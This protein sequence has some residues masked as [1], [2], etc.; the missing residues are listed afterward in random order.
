[1][2]EANGKKTGQTNTGFIRA[3]RAKN[4]E[5]YTR[6]E[7]IEAELH[8]YR[9]HFVGKTVYCNCD[10]PKV[11]QFWKYFYA[12]FSEWGLKRLIATGYKSKNSE[13]FSDHKYDTSWCKEY[14]GV[15]ETTRVLKS[16]GDFRK[17]ECVEILRRADI[18]VTNPPFSLFRDYIAQLVAEKKKFLVIGNYGSVTYKDI[19]QL[20]MAGKLWI[21]V[22]PR[23][24]IFD[25][26]GEGEHNVNSTW[27]TNL[28]HKK[29]HE[30]LI[31]TG[32]YKKDK[33]A[34]PK[35][36]NYDAIEV[37]KVNN[38]PD[39]YDGVMGV[40][41]TFLEKWNPDQFELLGNNR[42]HDGSWESYDI[43][44]INGKSTYM[45]ILIKNKGV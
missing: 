15:T 38:I 21:G 5:F 30:E 45:R 2:T 12:K 28:D 40:P 25:T 34:Y 33:S 35:Y 22:S 17:P 23:G 11:S 31:L 44:F 20:I 29:R 27:F 3:R 16:D 32:S 14:D 39:D 7:T 4:D 36:D 37:N 9:H 6:R 8:Y 19:F 26:P 10:D 18:V 1:M 24:M 13:L 41:I 42:W 43:N